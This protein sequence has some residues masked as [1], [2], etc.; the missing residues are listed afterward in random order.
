MTGQDIRYQASLTA[1]GGATGSITISLLDTASGRTAA[2]PTTCSGLAFT[3]EAVDRQ[4]RTRPGLAA[5]RPPVRGGH[6]VPLRARRAHGLQHHKG[7]P[8]H[9]V[10]GR[11]C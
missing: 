7:W 4:L 10:N 1:P 5:A 8:V 2:G 11:W 6:V 3:G 9:V